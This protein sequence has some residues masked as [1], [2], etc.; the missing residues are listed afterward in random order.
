M[1]VVSSL[2]NCSSEVKNI[3]FYHE[4][5]LGLTIEMGLIRSTLQNYW[6][7]YKPYVLYTVC[8]IWT[9]THMFANRDEGV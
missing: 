1:S 4:I 8:G 6:V 9:A 2:R 5:V 7:S 3:G